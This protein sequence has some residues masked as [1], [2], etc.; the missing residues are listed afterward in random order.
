MEGKEPENVI[1]HYKPLPNWKSLRRYFFRSKYLT[2]VPILLMDY[3]EIDRVI[4]DLA[5]S[6]A[7]P[8]ATTWFKISDIKNPTISDYRG[9]VIEFMNN[10]RD[11]IRQSYP[12]IE[13]EEG[14]KD[15]VFKGLDK[16]I[17]EVNT[18]NN[19]EVERRY[20]Y[21]TQYN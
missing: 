2:L 14:L 12:G 8:C 19:K 4:E 18:G 7:A 11:M 6:I 20:R 5:R 17:R 21:Y 10:F 3:F 9:K 1:D 13:R 15:Y 16:A